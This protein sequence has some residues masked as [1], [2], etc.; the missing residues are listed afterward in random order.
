MSK[1]DYHHPAELFASKRSGGARQPLTYRRFK[2]AAEAI[3][4]AVEDLGDVRAAGAWMQVDDERFD[5]EAIL[6]LY[7]SDYYPL[8]R[9]T[10]PAN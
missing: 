6:R 9:R 8:R 2:T 7:Q 10:A 3:R 1:F 4:F 5:G